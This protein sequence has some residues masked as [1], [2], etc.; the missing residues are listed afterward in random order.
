MPG[1]NKIIFRLAGISPLLVRPVFAGQDFITRRW[2]EAALR[3]GVR[4]LPEA[5][6][7][8]LARPMVM[9]AFI[10]DSR[11]ASPTT[12]R[13]GAQD[14]ALFA[15]DW[16]FAFEDI[17]VPVHIWHGDADRNVPESHGRLQ[18]D[19]IPGSVFHRCPGEGHLLVV[20]H[21][22]EILRTVTDR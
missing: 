5:D 20:D 22:G 12:A 8:V 18:A 2:P 4:Q 9:Q 13:A 21:L 11:M 15:G 17:T 3:A 19:R 16:G 1:I 7:T 10:D 14:F 6:A